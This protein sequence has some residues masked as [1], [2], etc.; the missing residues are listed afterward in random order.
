MILRVLKLLDFQPQMGILTR[1]LAAA[2]GDLLNFFILWGI[3]FVS[4]AYIGNLCFGG[5]MDAV[6]IPRKKLEGNALHTDA[7]EW[8]KEARLE[9]E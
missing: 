8:C 4:Y 6:S 1:A 2:G 7:F 5:N 9:T 3:I